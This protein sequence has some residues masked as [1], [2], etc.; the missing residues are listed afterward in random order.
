[1]HAA[2]FHVR[3][4]LL[5]AQATRLQPCANIVAAR[6]LPPM[7]FKPSFPALQRLEDDCDDESDDEGMDGLPKH[8]PLEKADWLERSL[9]VQPMPQRYRRPRQNT[10]AWDPTLM[11][12]ED[13]MSSTVPTYTPEV[14]D[15]NHRLGAMTPEE[16]DHWLDGFEIPAEAA[17]LKNKTPQQIRELYAKQ[18]RLEQAIYEMSVDTNNE[19]TSNVVAIQKGSEM[20]SAKSYINKWAGPLTSAIMDEIAEVSDNNRESLVIDRSIYGPALYLLAP[21][22]LARIVVTT[23]LN[24]VLMEADGVKFVKI[25]LALGKEIQ[26]EIKKEKLKSRTSG[27]SFE[28]NYTRIFQDNK[29]ANIRARAM[30]YFETVGDWSKELQLKLG[31]ALLDLVEKNCFEEVQPVS[32]SGLSHLS[33]DLP[34][35]PKQV[36]AFEHTVRFEKNRRY[37]II[38]CGPEVYQKIM[39]GDVF[40]PWC[41]RYL[42][43]IVPPRPWQGV[44]NGGYLTLPTTIMRHRDSRW[45]IQCAKRGEMDAVVESLNL[46]ADIPWVINRDVFNVVMALWNNGGGFGDLPPRDDIPLP[47]EPRVENYQH[48]SDEAERLSKYNAD[49]DTYKK[50]LAKIVKKNREYHSLRCDT[51]Y[52]LQVAEEFQHEEAVYFPYNMDFRGRVYPIPPNLNHLGS[53]MSR[54]LLVFKEKKPLGPGGLRWLKI[55]LANLYGIDKCSFDDREKFSNDHMKQILASAANPLG[56]D[57]DSKWWQDAESPFLALGV[58]FELAKAMQHPNPEEYMCNLPVHQ[59]GSCNGLQHYAALGR[60]QGGAEQVNLVPSDKPQDVYTGV[61][62]RVIRRM[63]IDSVK[64]IPSLEQIIED[65]RPEFEKTWFEEE[66][67][68]AS[69]ASSKSRRSAYQLKKVL[70]KDESLIRLAKAKEYELKRRHEYA[71]LLLNSITRKVVKQTVMTSVYGVTYIGARRQIQARLEEVFLMEGRG[72]DEE[73][74]EQIYHAANYAAELTM[75]SMGDLF[76]S[77]RLIMEWLSKCTE[78]VAN[79]GQMMSW[80]TPLGLPVTQPYR[81]QSTKQVRTSMQHVIIT[82]NDS[83]RVSVGRQKSAFPPNYVH[84]LDS[85]HMMMTSLK[86]IG[87]DKLDFAAVHDSYWTH[88]CSVDRMNTRLRQEFVT[89]Y[90]QPLLHDLREQLVIRFPRQEFPPVPEVGQLDLKEVLE[91]PYFFN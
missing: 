27:P 25:T 60:D 87:E 5:G 34:A 89:L 55:H 15:E 90:S 23:V 42:P 28:R 14:K 1:M 41:A 32:E 63:E 88:A 26:E 12:D 54:S 7:R 35:P 38:R 75:Q 47:E 56:D 59:D 39:N 91:S 76:T 51:I 40:L 16:V 48:I 31:S 22:K 46:L 44:A 21:D 30:E 80:I 13:V 6:R 83:K 10:V 24:H 49:I 57:P 45:Q 77:A 81:I 70:T 50:T 53:D 85:T 9:N 29:R 43:M 20:G 4:L 18:L 68:R 61:A 72:M 3:R 64:E 71:N 65:L 86:V 2:R 19:T 58:V 79:E 37:G 74:E 82:D 8:L 33:E 67:L 62:S 36:K 78:L 66:K 52:K 17:K 84:S 69:G 73:L 11:L